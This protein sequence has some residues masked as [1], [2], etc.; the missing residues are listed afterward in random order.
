MS[1]KNAGFGAQLEVSCVIEPRDKLRAG[2]NSDGGVF[3][4]VTTGEGVSLSAADSIFLANYLLDS[5]RCAAGMKP[6]PGVVVPVPV[7]PR[8]KIIQ[9]LAFATGNAWAPQQLYCLCDDGTVWVR[10]GEGRWVQLPE[11]E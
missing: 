11:V 8:R 4:D 3:V 10:N 9:L 5:V 7:S 6:Q 1:I 2:P